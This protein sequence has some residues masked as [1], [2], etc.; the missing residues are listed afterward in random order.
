MYQGIRKRLGI[1]NVLLFLFSVNVAGCTVPNHIDDKIAAIK[2]NLPK[3]C[4]ITITSACRTP[5]KNKEVGGARRSYHLKNR[6]RDVV[7]NCR[8]GII[9]EAAK[10]GLSTLIYSTHIHLDDR[11]KQVCLVRRGKGFISCKK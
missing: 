9:R 1:T 3:Y 11:P 4:K 7:S 8:T 10:V 5:K 6:A 2:K